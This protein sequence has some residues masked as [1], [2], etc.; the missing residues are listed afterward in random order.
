MIAS[1]CSARGGCGSSRTCFGQLHPRVT[2]GVRLDADV[3]EQE[4][5][6]SGTGRGFRACASRRGWRSTPRSRSAVIVEGSVTERLV[7]LLDRRAV[8]FPRVHVDVDPGRQEPLA[9]GLE[10]DD[11]RRRR[12][13]CTEHVGGIPPGCDLAGD[14]V[15]SDLR[16]LLVLNEPACTHG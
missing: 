3:V 7:D 14:E 2:R 1:K 12:R 4:P 11:S 15:A 8:V 16:L 6:R 10:A 13:E 5:E 9:P